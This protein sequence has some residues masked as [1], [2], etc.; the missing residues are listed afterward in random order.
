METFTHPATWG[1]N[2]PP[3]PDHA[4]ISR[5]RLDAY[6]TSAGICAQVLHDHAAHIERLLGVSVSRGQE[7]IERQLAE[8]ADSMFAYS[9]RLL[10]HPDISTPTTIPAP[11]E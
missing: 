8:P 1:S 7:V 3:E 4:T 5:I 9:G 11:T 6:G 10:L 2:G